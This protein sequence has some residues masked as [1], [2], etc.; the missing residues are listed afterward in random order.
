[1]DNPYAP[2]KLDSQEPVHIELTEPAIAKATYVIDPNYVICRNRCK[3]RMRIDHQLR[4]YLR[5]VGIAVLPLIAI[6]QAANNQGEWFW[7]IAPSAAFFYLLFGVG[8]YERLRIF[9]FRLTGLLG[10]QASCEF[11]LEGILLVEKEAAQFVPT[12]ELIKAAMFGEGLLLVTKTDSV[13]FIPKSSVNN[14]DQLVEFLRSI[15]PFDERYGKKSLNLQP[16]YDKI[17]NSE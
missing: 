6:A 10:E 8:I 12:D 1:M 2:P 9:I 7:V 14:D 11:F 16:T 5:V 4:V 17:D 13:V 15:V 3:R